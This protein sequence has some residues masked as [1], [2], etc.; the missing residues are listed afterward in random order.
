M[1]HAN[2]CPCCGE[3]IMPGDQHRNCCDFYCDCKSINNS[4]DAENNVLQYLVTHEDNG[5]DKEQL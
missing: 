4:I 3:Q 2:I 1:L 5:I